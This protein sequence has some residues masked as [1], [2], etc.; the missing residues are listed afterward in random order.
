MT[1]SSDFIRLHRR[2]SKPFMRRL[3]PN[4]R[5][6]RVAAG[7]HEANGPCSTAIGK[8]GMAMRTGIR[9]WWLGIVALALAA[10]V[11][12]ASDITDPIEQLDA[13][14]LEVMKAGKAAPF[15]Q[16]Y[17]ILAPRV[18]RAIDLDAIL[19]GGVGTAAWSSLSPRS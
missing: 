9:R 7:N 3:A 17:D 15:Q 19:Q 13:G 18:I 11:A 4:F 16:R 5:D 2:K 10:P 12:R 8:R 6:H 1:G 14:L